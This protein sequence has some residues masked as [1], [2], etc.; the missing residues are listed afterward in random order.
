[1]VAISTEEE[2]VVQ[3]PEMI[4]GAYEGEMD[5]ESGRKDGATKGKG[6]SK[7]VS[8]RNF[9]YF[10]GFRLSAH[11][12]HLKP[13]VPEYRSRMWRKDEVGRYGLP[14]LGVA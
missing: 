4:L 11:R 10:T 1:M 2:T 5:T 13:V 6:S 8:C 14:S 12:R 9:F 7:S 3:Q